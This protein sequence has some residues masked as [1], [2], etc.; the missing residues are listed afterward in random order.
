MVENWNSEISWQLLTPSHS[1]DSCYHSN[2]SLMAVGCQWQKKPQQ[3][4]LPAGKQSVMKL[5]VGN[6]SQDYYNDHKFDGYSS[7]GFLPFLNSLT[8]CMWCCRAR[9]CLTGSELITTDR[10][11]CHRR[12]FSAHNCAMS[13][14]AATRKSSSQ[15]TACR[16]YSSMR[17]IALRFHM[18][19]FVHL[20]HSACLWRSFLNLLKSHA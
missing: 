15:S 3:N 17:N 8:L 6:D 1:S 11:C 12:I 16:M 14:L 5:R 10:K 9:C 13:L 18:Y 2:H 7:W 4:V 19:N 20:F